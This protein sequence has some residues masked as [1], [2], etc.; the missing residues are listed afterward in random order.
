[1]LKSMSFPLTVPNR[2]SNGE[3]DL[4]LRSPDLYSCIQFEIRTRL[5][6]EAANLTVFTT[7]CPKENQTNDNLIVKYYCF[8]IELFDKFSFSGNLR[9]C[10]N[11]LNEA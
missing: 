7:I 2:T 11:H 4:P 9:G 1:M 5:A 10:L 6:C 8:I 3:I